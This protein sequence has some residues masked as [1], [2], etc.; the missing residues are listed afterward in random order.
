MRVS[1]GKSRDEGRPFQGI[2]TLPQLL[3]FLQQF[4]RRNAGRPFQTIDTV[5]DSLTVFLY[6][7]EI[8]VSPSS[9]LS[10]IITCP[11]RVNSVQYNRIHQ[12]DGEKYY[13][14]VNEKGE[15]IN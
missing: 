7:V 3:L 6:P 9:T 10:P 15:K 12:T 14:K 5:L 11:K 13:G 8:K 2:D 4:R 1:R